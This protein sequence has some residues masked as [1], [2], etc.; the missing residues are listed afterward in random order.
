MSLHI[1]PIPDGAAEPLALMHRDCFP[2]DPWNAASFARLSALY[3]VFGYL[4]WLDEGPSDKAPSDKALSDDA[5]GDDALGDDA[6]GDDALGGFILAR[7]LGGEAEILT[8]GVLPR[9]RR[10]GVG[11]A[12]LD[13]VMA[14]AGRRRL[15]SVVLEVAADN[16]AA[17]LLYGAT[18]FVRVGMRPRYY[19]R[20]HGAID[21]LILRRPIGAYRNHAQP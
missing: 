10:L 9:T 1:A 14:E 5:L 2:E 6:L 7:D 13:A 4:A 19:R 8:L 3:G 18:G 11:R 20:D 12:L 15:G 16:A 17:R 21:A